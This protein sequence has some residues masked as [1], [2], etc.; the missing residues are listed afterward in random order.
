MIASALI[1]CS[2]PITEQDKLRHRKPTITE[3]CV[4][5]LVSQLQHR[6][7]AVSSSRLTPAR[8]ICQPRSPL[9]GTFLTPC[10]VQTMGKL[11]RLAATS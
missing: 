10:A 4:T 8:Q 6:A 11:P 1:A 5:S 9:S 7:F 3:L 2:Y